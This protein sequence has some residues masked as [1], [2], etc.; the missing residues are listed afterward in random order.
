MIDPGTGW[1]EVKEIKNKE[2]INIANILEQ[3]W[4]TR[5]PWLQILQYN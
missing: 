5:Y 1:F 4:L 2:A 3:T